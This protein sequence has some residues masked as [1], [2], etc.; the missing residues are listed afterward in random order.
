MSIQSC[1]TSQLPSLS[2]MW[3]SWTLSKYS[4]NTWTHKH[5]GRHRQKHTTDSWCVRGWQ[6]WVSHLVRDAF[7]HL[8]FVGV[9]VYDLVPQ[10]T[11][12]HVGPLD[13]H[14]TMCQSVSLSSA[15]GLYVMGKRDGGVL[16]VER[17][18]ASPSQV[19]SALLQ[20]K[21]TA[22]NRYTCNQ[23]KSILHI[24]QL[25]MCSL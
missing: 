21:A 6:F 15:A 3:P 18:T 25:I 13:K 11:Q 23:S 12:S 24:Q 22:R 20:T 5:N 2:R 19:L 7:L 1:T 10:R 16:P 14:S 4:F 17:R 9:W 8:C